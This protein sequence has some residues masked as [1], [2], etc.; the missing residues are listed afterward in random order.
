MRLRIGIAGLIAALSVSCVAWADDDHDKNTKAESRAEKE[1]AREASDRG[2]RVEKIGEADR[3]GKKLY[4]VKLRVDDRSY[5]ERR[6]RDDDFR[7]VCRYDA[8]SRRA[9][10][11]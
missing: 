3:V 4:E 9:Q 8:K 2:L 10:I 5:D 7:V 1:C 11:Y 6:R